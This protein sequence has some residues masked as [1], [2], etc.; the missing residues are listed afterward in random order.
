MQR[1]APPSLR[2]SKNKQTQEG[3]A[4]ALE[5]LEAVAQLACLQHGHVITAKAWI[6]GHTFLGF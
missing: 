6:R 2:T 4:K 1:R 3:Q 5:T